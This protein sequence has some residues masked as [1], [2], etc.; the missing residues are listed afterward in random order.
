[1][2]FLL[3]YSAALNP[4]K[5]AR[6]VKNCRYLHV[7]CKSKTVHEYKGTVNKHSE[8]VKMAIQQKEKVE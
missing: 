6:S 1:M 5:E 7:I 2:G 8:Y 4:C 3:F